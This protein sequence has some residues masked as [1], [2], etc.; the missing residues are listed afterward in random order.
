MKFTYKANFAVTPASG[1]SI[2]YG[3]AVQK[4]GTLNLFEQALSLR[5]Q[6]KTQEALNICD[7]LLAINPSDFNALHMIG[8]VH[9]EKGNYIESIRFIGRALETNPYVADAQSNLGNAYK[10]TDQH[11]FAV[12]CYENAIA[13]DPNHAEA[14]NNLGVMYRLRGESQ[15]S[16][17]VLD[18]AIALNPEFAEAYCNRGDTLEHLGDLTG[19][20]DDF[21]KALDLNGDLDNLL[22]SLLF[23]RSK[24][25][26]WPQPKE[27][28]ESLLA[29]IQTRAL[30]NT[31]PWKVLSLMDDPYLH[32]IA[33][34]IKAPRVTLP[35]DLVA[36]FPLS[37]TKA[38]IRVG[39]FS[40][41]FREHPIGYLTAE[42]F[43][44]N[45]KDKFELIAFT[46]D[47]PNDSPIRKR[48][49]A[50]FDKV[51]NV[52]KMP[53]T[54]V[55]DLCLN[56]KLDIAIDLIGHTLSSVAKL[57]STRIAPVQVNYLGYPGTM[58]ASYYD[59]VIA[60]EVTIP[61]ESRLFFAEKVA[62]MPDTFFVNDRKRAVSERQFTREELGLPAE[63]V[64]FCC[65]NNAYKISEA[66]F[67]RWLTIL[68]HVEGSVLWLS[69][70]SP[71][72]VENLR[73]Y[74]NIAGIDLRRLIFASKIPLHSE[75]LARYQYAD[76]FLDTSPYN[77]HTT[78]SDALWAGLPVLT[79]VGRSFASRVAASLIQAI[80]MPELI[81]TTED[82]YVTKAIRLANNPAELR[83]LRSR[84]VANRDLTPLFNTPQFAS[85]LEALFTL[86]H[87]RRRHSQPPEHLHLK[88][89]G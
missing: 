14:H 4:P 20:L 21:Q 71:T 44:L 80:G 16:R 36:T 79:L 55:R 45:D 38:K 39:Y 46:T 85:N 59:Y 34:E 51:I 58:G 62:Y 83:A 66:C 81:T 82:A 64:V 67:Q 5:E 70:I 8:V 56:E 15:K 53:E 9:F 41:D 33:A 57:F 19:A 84:I 32:R 26:L 65:F 49:E 87:Q 48:I 2:T 74:A 54:R 23:L 37:S 28:V 50:A 22:E 69:G 3:K 12:M 6:G 29:K 47:A 30:H 27:L 13:M 52:H 75:H 11:E 18:K 24:L 42:L 88:V 86:M 40:G 61:A 17:E 10:L 7:Q 89:P 76:L 73:S 31:M 25:L 78:A 35:V 43:E 77:A 72:A 1:Y 60:D 68:K 63:G